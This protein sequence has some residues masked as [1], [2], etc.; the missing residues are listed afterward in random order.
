MDVE[1]AQ[2]T[3]EK[4]KYDLNK[5]NGL[6]PALFFCGGKYLIFFRILT[7]LSYMC[8]RLCVIKTWKENNM[9]GWHKK[10]KIREKIITGQKIRYL[11]SVDIHNNRKKKK[12][13]YKKLRFP[14]DCLWF[15]YEQYSLFRTTQVCTRRITF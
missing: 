6:D 13:V 14:F 12:I 9:I 5:D 15:D 8:P 3:I 1:Y 11:D 2:K 10:K 7:Y 4:I